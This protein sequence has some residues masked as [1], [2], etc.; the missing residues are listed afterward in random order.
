MA[1]GNSA[2]AKDY[3]FI[4]RMLHR[5]AFAHPVLQR[6]LGEIESDMFSAKFASQT[7]ERPVFVT[8]LPRAGTTHMLEMLYKTGEFATFTYREMPFVLAPLFWSSITRS[9]RITGEK[10]ER[11]HGDGMEVSFDSPEA[12]EEVAWLSYLRDAFVTD[13]RL[14]PIG[15][16]K[17]SAEFRGAFINLVRKLA[18]EQSGENETRRYLSKNNANIGRLDA[19]RSVF[20]DAAIFV[21]L[22]EPQAHVRS[23]MTQHQRFLG[24]H[25]DDPFARDYMQWIGHYDFGANFRPIDF[26]G[27]GLSAAGASSV[28]FWLSYW[29]D[30]YRFAERRAGAGVSFVCYENLFSNPAGALTAIAGAAGLMD[31]AAFAA[32]AS[33][34]RQP[35]TA[36]DGLGAA[37]QNLLRDA[38]ALYQRLREHALGK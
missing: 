22:R 26:A 19:I 18:A 23:L 27:R 37:D 28:D 2:S 5:M 3:S 25:D 6:A 24:M 12:F 36:A 21:C 32:N 16:E 20:P 7:A 38:S 8:G 35:T 29:I 30:A 9:S 11:A 33:T 34:I 17:I 15:P 13:E 1:A 10:R 14:L 31:A 4:D